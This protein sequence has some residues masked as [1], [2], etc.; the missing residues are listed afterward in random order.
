MAQSKTEEQLPKAVKVEGRTCFGISWFDTEEKADRY[1]AWVVEKGI[2]YNGGFYHGR[3]C[4]RDKTG[5]KDGLF[6]VTD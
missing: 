2:T 1:A 6:A 5:D 4:G 3:P